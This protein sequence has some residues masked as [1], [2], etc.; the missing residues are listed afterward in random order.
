MTFKSFGNSRHCKKN[1]PFNHP[2]GRIDRFWSV[3]DMICVSFINLLVM[4]CV[5][6]DLLVMVCVSFNLLVIVGVSFINLLDMVCV[7]TMC[8]LPVNKS[9]P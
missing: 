8:L 7:E 4:V 5:F 3:C 1:L 9:Y 6:F 2:T